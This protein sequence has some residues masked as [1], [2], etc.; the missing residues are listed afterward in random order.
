LQASATFPVS[1]ATIRPT[2][3]PKPTET[4]KPPATS[5]P[6]VTPTATQSPG[7]PGLTMNSA[8]NSLKDKGFNCSLG[9]SSPGPTLWMCDIQIEN[10]TWYHVDLYGT[11]NVEV[12]NVFASVFQT[13]P[14]NAKA[15]DI[16][17]YVASL[18]YNGSDATSARQWIADTLSGIQSVNDVKEKYFGNVH[19]KL[20]GDPH[21]RYLEMGEPVQQQ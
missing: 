6:T 17:G 16:L 20:Y 18:P 4:P 13:Q 12:N 5:T 14:D 2:H 7:L 19:F 8:V 21:G 15:I 1:N 9:S 3:T 11:A 10:D